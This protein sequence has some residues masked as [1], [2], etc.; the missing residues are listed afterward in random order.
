MSVLEDV[1]QV[2]PLRALN[3]KLKLSNFSHIVHVGSNRLEKPIMSEGKQ[4]GGGRHMRWLDEIRHTTK[5][6]MHE[7]REVARDKIGSRHHGCHQK[8]TG[9]HI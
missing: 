3:L 1:S 8:L 7:L 5:I 4:K 2:L 6:T 9:H